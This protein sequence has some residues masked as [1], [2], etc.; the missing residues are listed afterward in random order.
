VFES[1]AIPSWMRASSAG[2]FR[3]NLRLLAAFCFIFV[4]LT[5]AGLAK[6]DDT[7]RLALI[8]KI[9]V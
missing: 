7:C 1:A 8:V 9:T 6:A 2:V 3:L 5:V 4:D